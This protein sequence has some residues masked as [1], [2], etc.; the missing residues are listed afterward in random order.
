M[1]QGKRHNPTDET[2]KAVKSETAMGVSQEVVAQGIGISVDTLAKYYRDELDTAS[3][4]ACSAVAGYL[5][6]TATGKNPQATAS[7]AVRAGMFW[8]KTRAGWRETMVQ[9]HSGPNGG[10][11]QTITGIQYEVLEPSDDNG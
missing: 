9:E 6:T 11:I 1:A 8:M 3:E 5:Y 10:P 4:R 2:R 7:D